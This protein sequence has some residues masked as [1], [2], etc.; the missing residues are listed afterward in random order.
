MA[1][2]LSSHP[3]A[4]LLG[5]VNEALWVGVGMEFI[6]LQTPSFVLRF[7]FLPVQLPSVTAALHAMASRVTVV[8]VDAAIVSSIL[9]AAGATGGARTEVTLVGPA[10]DVTVVGVVVTVR[11][12]AIT[13]I[14][15]KTVVDLATFHG[16]PVG[17][18]I[19]RVAAIDAAAIDGS[20]I[21]CHR[22]G[23]RPGCASKVGSC[24]PPDGGTRTLLRYVPRVSSM[25]VTTATAASL[26]ATSEGAVFNATFVIERV[27]ATSI[28]TMRFARE[29][30]F[31]AE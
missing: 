23:N 13:A 9:L 1:V 27:F 19:F 29:W 2:Q 25:P 15:D 8:G 16:A 17:G 12:L 10:I 7:V 4:S 6:T 22:D 30:V 28:Y 18:L 21:G 14:T 11:M 26:L 31:T 3:A 5:R 20:E 24:A